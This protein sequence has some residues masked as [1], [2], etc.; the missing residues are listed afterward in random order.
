MISRYAKISEQVLSAGEEF[1]DRMDVS[2]DTHEML[3]FSFFLGLFPFAGFLFYYT[4]VGRIWNEWPL[5]NTTLPVPRGLMCAGLQWIFFA[6][7]PTI[8]TL[9][10]EFLFSR[11]LARFDAQSLTAVCNY[12]MVPMHLAA[13]FV[14]V[15]FVQRSTTLVGVVA[16]M[17]LLFYGYRRY[18]KLGITGATVLTIGIFALFSLIRQM[19][20]F[21]IGF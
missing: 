14:G 20:V 3:R 2:T 21:V 4:V 10:L 16:F 17:Y 19:F 13:L 11:R 15:P 9:I 6:T 1:W 18:L 12:S 7:F 8:S 5:I